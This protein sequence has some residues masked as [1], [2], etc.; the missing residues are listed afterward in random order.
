MILREPEAPDDPTPSEQLAYVVALVCFIR[1][2]QR[3]AIRGS[4]VG[5]M[6]FAAF[7]AIGLRSVT[8]L[9]DDRQRDLSS[10]RVASCFQS[11]RSETHQDGVEKAEALSDASA[12]K[13]EAMN[14]ADH[15]APAPRSTLVQ[16]LVDQYL[17]SQYGVIDTNLQQ[18]DKLIDSEHPL[19]DCSPDGIRRFLSDPVQDETTTTIEPPKGKP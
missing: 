12:R 8:H 14:T 16:G 9:A 6:I 5:Y 18:K 17:A 2:R 7:F 15:I 10:Q 3:R 19:R 11:R 1:D 13:R 4:I